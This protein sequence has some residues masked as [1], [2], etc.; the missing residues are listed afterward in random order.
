MI[1]LSGKSL[2]LVFPSR[3]PPLRPPWHTNRLDVSSLFSLTP[4]SYSRQGLFS[5]LRRPEGLS[6]NK[7]RKGFLH[8][9]VGVKESAICILPTS[10]SRV[11][12]MGD[13]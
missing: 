4:V 9:L 5:T 3:A 2:L 11:P 1:P 13:N 8:M 10:S 7:Q 12:M 6:L